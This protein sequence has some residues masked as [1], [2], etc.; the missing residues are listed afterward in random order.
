MKFPCIMK[1]FEDNRILLVMRKDIEG[2]CLRGFV[3]IQD[4]GRL[5][6]TIDRW[7]ADYKLFIKNSKESIW[8]FLA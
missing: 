7:Y 4:V 2:C 3:L 6:S 5:D 8:D 1:C